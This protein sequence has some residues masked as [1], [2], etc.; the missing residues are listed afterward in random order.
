VDEARLKSFTAQ[1]KGAGITPEQAAQLVAYQVG[2]EKL[3]TESWA[4]Q[5]ENW[6]G[7]LEK[8]GEFGG[9]NLKASEAAL[10]SALR[11]FDPK[12][13]LVQD[14]EKYGVENLP[15]LARF[16]RRVG[17]A[18]AEDKGTVDTTRTQAKAMTKEEI[19]LAKEFPSIKEI[20]PA[21]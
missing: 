17:L 14:L 21:E 3:A 4:K 11:R 12:G 18:G 6:Y 9:A 19:R 16:L 13:E 7:E 5:G 1:A 10:Q 8:D 2:Q 15:S 20:Q